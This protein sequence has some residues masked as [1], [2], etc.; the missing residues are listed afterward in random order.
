MK[1][2]AYEELAVQIII[3]YFSKHFNKNYRKKFPQHEQRREKIIK[4]LERWGINSES[5]QDEIEVLLE[6]EENI[7]RIKAITLKEFYDLNG[8]EFTLT[9]VDLNDQ[10]LRLFNHK[11][12]PNLPLCKAVKFSGSFPV[13]FKSHKW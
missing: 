12:A 6:E 10:T 1:G 8:V 9:A 2:D 3:D 7:E 13:A 4:I 11:T 5:S